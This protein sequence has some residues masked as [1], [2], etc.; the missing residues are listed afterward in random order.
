MD[1]GATPP[2]HLG[3]VRL[4]DGRRLGWAQWGPPDGRPVLFFSGAGM[5]RSLGFGGHVTAALGVRLIAVDRP[6]L[7]ASDPAPGRT[8]TDWAADV[9]ALAA[10]LDLGRFRV[11]A[12]SQGAPFA[13]A[14]AAD[15][16]PEAV[17]VVSGQDDLRH[18]GVAGLLP[19][20]VARMVAAAGDDP[21]GLEASFGAMTADALHRLV[22][23]LS[24]DA[25]TAVYTA[26]DFAGA[27][28]RCLAEGFSQGAAGYARDAVL[29]MGPWPFAP[30]RIG[31]PVALWYGGRDTSPVHSPDHGATLA[32]RIP[33]TR[34][35]L[36]PEAGGALLWTHAEAILAALLAEGR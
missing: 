19:P 28:A 3:T 31:V 2:D 32:G 29:A 11:A 14:C 16:T 23:D 20:D 34:R 22:L 7:G 17:A 27:Y 6:G 33:G 26:A 1:L 36:L 12:F 9:R 30:E 15:G 21:A 24:A 25:D 35:H 4:A 18:P 8:L 13:L 10:A 5:G